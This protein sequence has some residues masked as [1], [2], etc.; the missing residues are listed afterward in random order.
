VVLGANVFVLLGPNF[1]GTRD[2]YQR[3][4]QATGL[5]AYDLHARLRKGVWG[6]VKLLGD[7]REAEALAR[8]LRELGFDPVLIDRSVLHDLERRPLLA[9]SI[10][11]GERELVV[12]LP[13]QELHVGYEALAVIVRGEVQ[14]GRTAAAANPSSAS[15]RAAVPSPDAFARDPQRLS[16]EGYQ[17]ADL[18]FLEV[19]WIARVGTRA[20]DPTGLESG[21]RALDVL[22]D[23]IAARA[24]IRV[25]RGSRTSSVAAF[26]EQPAP[27][28]SQHSTPPSLRE[29]TDERFDP[30]SRVIGE[31]E[32]QLRSV[33]RSA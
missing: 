2:A 17:A 30:Y 18:H 12:E 14:P 27:L 1:E 23:E 5:V 13:D 24:S 7:A 21:P 4:S 10:R 22:V 19:P 11:L 8:S 20:L 16:F 15:L 6:V 31:A 29:Q 26:V 28:R 9:S 32:R 3:L 33:V 25:D